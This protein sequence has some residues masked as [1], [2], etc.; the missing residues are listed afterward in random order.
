MEASSA[1]W[2]TVNSGSKRDAD[3]VRPPSGN[4]DPMIGELNAY[5]SSR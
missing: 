2:R 5:T 4:D 1:R 3:G